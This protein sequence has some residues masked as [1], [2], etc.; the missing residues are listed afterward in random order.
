[1]GCFYPKPVIAYTSMPNRGLNVMLAESVYAFANG[2]KELAEILSHLD[3]IIMKSHY[4]S[5]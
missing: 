1:M 5:G 2:K 4:Y 3:E